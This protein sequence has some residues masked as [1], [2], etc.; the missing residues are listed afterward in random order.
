MT[1]G[2]QSVFFRHHLYKNYKVLQGGILSALM[3]CSVLALVHVLCKRGAFGGVKGGVLFYIGL[4]LDRKM[5]QSSN[6]VYL[7]SDVGDI[8]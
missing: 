3:L 8:K 1:E 6:L 2:T 5:V 7:E 4:A